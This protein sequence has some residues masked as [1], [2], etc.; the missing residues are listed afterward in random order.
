MVGGL[1]DHKTA[2]QE[3]RCVGVIAEPETLNQM[4]H[5]DGEYTIKSRVDVNGNVEWSP[6]Q[7]LSKGEYWGRRAVFPGSRQVLDWNA[8]GR[9]LTECKGNE[10]PHA[11]DGINYSPFF[12]E[13]AV[14]YA[15]NGRQT[16]PKTADAIWDMIVWLSKVKPS[17]APLS[18]IYR[19]SQL[20]DKFKEEI[21]QEWNDVFASDLIEV[22]KQD[23]KSEAEGGNP[24]QDL[25]MR[26]FD[27]YMYALDIEMNQHL[28]FADVSDSGFFNF[29]DPVN[30]LDAVKNKDQYD[31]RYK[32]FISD[33]QKR[34]DEINAR[35]D[36]G[37]LSQLI[38][39][40]ERWVLY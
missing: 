10:C 23:F 8:P 1:C 3:G 39:W 20:T 15:I 13:G 9:P 14:S 36:G 4:L 30:S 33:L 21:S 17:E 18:G 37:A 7:K 27:E 26:G 24:A 28:I 5:E 19:T 11:V 35:Q 12:S 31:I 16:K 38:L 34:Y 22:L 6:G 32:R 29:D 40:R 2:F 25:M